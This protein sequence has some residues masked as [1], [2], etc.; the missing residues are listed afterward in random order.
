M[1]SF[2]RLA[3]GLESDTSSAKAKIPILLRVALA[4]L[5]VVAINGGP[6]AIQPLPLALPDNNPV[7]AFASTQLNPA[8]SAHEFSQPLAATQC[9]LPLVLKNYALTYTFA[10]QPGS[11]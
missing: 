5:L 4:L 1:P 11:P 8:P 2:H 9:F 7:T 3:V 10:L 6:T